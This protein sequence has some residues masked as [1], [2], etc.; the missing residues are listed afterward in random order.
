MR[1]ITTL[2]G[3]LAALVLTAGLI[4]LGTT[5][6]SNAAGPI[7]SGGSGADASRGTQTTKERGVVIECTGTHRGQDVWL[8]VYEND[9]YDN[10]F[11]V[12]VGD[13]GTGASRVVEAGFV[14][15]G[16][17]RASLRLKGKKVVVAGTATRYGRKIPVHAEHDDAGQHIVEDGFHRKL[18]TDLTMAWMNR[19]VGLDCDNAF[20][21]NL[22]V[23][24]TDTANR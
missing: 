19:T 3:L 21:Y 23:T 2:I 9:V 20:F 7:A 6:A 10:V 5:A 11:Q 18:R 12:V 14:D 15:R 17:V 24:K 8:S 13:N 22:S 1:K 4:G 16:E